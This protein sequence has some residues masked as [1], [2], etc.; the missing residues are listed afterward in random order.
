MNLRARWLVAPLLATLLAGCGSG[1]KEVAA[2]APASL[3]TLVVQAA[4]GSEGRGWDGVVEAVR[5]ATLSAQTDGRVGEVLAD[6]DDRVVAGQVLLRLSAVEQQSGVEAA[7]AQL[8]AAQAAASEA[9]ANYRRFAD[10]AEGQFVSAAQLDQARRMRDS[11][12]AARDAARAQLASAGQQNAYTV[13]RAPYA[14]IVS[15]RAVEPGESVASGRVLMTLFAPEALRIEVSVPQSDAEAVRAEPVARVRFDDGRQV[16]A[17]QVTVFP[18]ADAATH[19]VKVR[20]QLPALEPVPRPGSSAR[21]MFPVLKGAAGPR[22]PASA[23]LRRGEVNAV[24]VLADGRLSLR[25]VRL[26]EPVGGEV[27]VIAGLKPGERIAADPLVA[28][29]A[30]AAARGER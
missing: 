20:V 26:G 3:P 9:E 23:L 6:V 8:R 17:A 27:E 16:E 13:V 28:M 10:L 24:Y 19:A 14:G 2:A 11:T 30:L 1:G 5:Q 7:R 18:A 22:V 12:V 25:Q 21:V 4:D 29:Q 15:S